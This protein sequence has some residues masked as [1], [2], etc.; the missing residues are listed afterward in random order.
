MENPRF[1][2]KEIKPQRHRDTEARLGFRAK[3][4][5]RISENIF[6]ELL[7]LVA[8]ASRCHVQM[9]GVGAASAA[10]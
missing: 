1:N 3:M 5:N 8:W 7:K 4:A 9:I 6:L 10:K 2:S